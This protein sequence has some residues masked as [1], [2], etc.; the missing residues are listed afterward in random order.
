LAEKYDIVVVG[1]GPSGILAAK[2]AAEKGLKVLLLERGRQPGDKSVGGEFLPISIFQRFPWMKEGPVE[3]AMTKWGFHFLHEDKLTELKFSR[4]NGEYG[5]TVHRPSWDRWTSGFAEAAGATL[6]TSTL[7]ENLLFDKQN[8]VVGVAAEGGEKFYSSVVIGAD[9]SNSTVALKASLRSRWPLNAL[10]LC[11]KHTYL[12]SEEE[13][14]RRF[15]DEN[16]GGELKIFLSEKISPKGYGWIF[17]SKED[18]CV[19]VG[20]ALDVLEESIEN[21]LSN[22]LDFPLVRKLTQG[23]TV[24]QHSVHTVPVY[25]PQGK[26][27]AHGVLLVGDAAG[28]VCP[29]DGA[30]YEAAVFSGKLAAEVA[31]EAL[32]EGDCSAEALEKY[33]KK[34]KKSWMGGDIDTGARLQDLILNGIG[35]GRLSRLLYE[36]GAALSKHGS[37]LDK[38][39]KESLAEFL[40]QIED[41]RGLFSQ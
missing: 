34:W 18:F 37:Y 40:S 29:M 6:K 33:E 9:G 13:I 19:G 15:C 12:L 5:F 30:G 41:L 7:V 25:G 22:F 32:G 21:R 1:A 10:A 4:R 14:T 36:L 26:T 2:T 17:P 16:D 11:V 3:R 28:F 24:F 38:S 31:A 23:A 39:H 27:Y 8:H 35:I 20:S